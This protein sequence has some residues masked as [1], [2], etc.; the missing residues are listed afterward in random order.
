[1]DVN[2]SI[3]LAPYFAAL[4]SYEI[5]AVRK[6]YEDQGEADAGWGALQNQLFGH[7]VHGQEEYLETAYILRQ[8]FRTNSTRS[9]RKAASQINQVCKP[10]NATGPDFPNLSSK[11][12]AQVDALPSGEW[13]KRPTQVRYI[14]KDGTDVSLEFQWAPK[15]SVVYGGTFTGLPI[16]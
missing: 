3:Y 2:R 8:T 10:V 5:L 14:G 9:I 13:L 1:V 12:K 15:W 4:T 16:A 7:L 6:A 11:M